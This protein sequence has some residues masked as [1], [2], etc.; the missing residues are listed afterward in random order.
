[1]IGIQRTRPLGQVQR[2]LGYGKLMQHKLQDMADILGVKLQTGH[3]CNRHAVLL[4]Q[5]KGQIHGTLA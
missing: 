5:L 2:D 1:M 3:E 4:F